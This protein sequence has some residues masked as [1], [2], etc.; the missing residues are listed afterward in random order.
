[1]SLFS[2]LSGEMYRTRT[3]RP[4]GGRRHRPSRQARKAASVLPD[5]VGAKISVLRPAAM[6]G[7]PCRCAGV[8]SPSVCRNHSRTGGRKR[9]RASVAS[10]RTLY[11]CALRETWRS[12]ANGLRDCDCGREP[13]EACFEVHQ[14]ALPLPSSFEFG[15]DLLEEGSWY[16]VDH[17]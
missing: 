15:H 3:P 12:F 11:T 4:A 6:E 16:P 1:M 7:Q 10:M 13:T 2:A 17:E 14:Q 8:G 9:S 5:P